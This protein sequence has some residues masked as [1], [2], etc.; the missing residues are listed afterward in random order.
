MK[1]KNSIALLI[2]FAVVTLF[3]FP[4]FVYANI[5]ITFYIQGPGAV[6]LVDTPLVVPENCTVVDSVGGSHDFSGYKAP[7][8]LLAA[9]DTGVIADFL[10]KDFG[11]L[12]LFLDSVNGIA[13]GPAPDFPYWNLWLNGVFSSVGINEI[14][15]SNGDIFQLTYGPFTTPIIQTSQD[16]LSGGPVIVDV[17]PRKLDVESAVSFLVV[18]QQ[19]DGSFGFPIFT[20]WAAVALG[21]YEGN[22]ASAFYS[23]NALGEWLI[24]NP[25]LEGSVVTDYERRAMALLS[26]GINPYN[27]TEKNYI[28]A[29]VQEF[30]GQQFGSSNLVNDDIFAVLVLRKVGYEVNVTPLLETLDFIFAWQ[31]E[32]GSFGSPDIT[33]AAVQVLSLLPASEQRDKAMLKAREY[34][35]E[36]QENS[37][38]FGNV[39]STSWILQA[40]VALD[41]DGDAW[42]KEVDRRTPEHFLALNQDLD[43][44]LLKGETKENRIWAT[45]Y[46]IPA[47]LEKPWGEIFSQITLPIPTVTTEVLVQEPVA[48]QQE[49]FLFAAAKTT[50]DLKEEIQSQIDLITIKIALLQTQARLDSVARQVAQLQAIRLA[51]KEASVASVVMGETS[52]QEPEIV[53]SIQKEISLQD[54]R[55]EVAATAQSE[56]GSSQIPLYILAVLGGAALFWAF[57]GQNILRKRNVQNIPS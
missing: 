32:N 11:G 16:V 56:T 29:I 27:G 24:Q 22:S 28:E 42:A 26:L 19:E 15:L 47:A 54:L 18:N 37:G 31:G 41:E 3:A 5:N 35:A 4:G 20:D 1:T 2:F 44:G 14:V 21:A 52:I 51:I 48:Q 46:A 49:T 34:L 50:Q 10:F 38:G 33:A 45:A 23:I 36:Q 57:G 17:Y 55:A 7:C 43:G 13:S 12:G 9:K 53:A 6:V 30:D 39:Y 8:A 40:I 25:V